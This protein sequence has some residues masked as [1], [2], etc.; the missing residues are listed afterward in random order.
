MTAM[1]EGIRIVEIAGGPAAAFAGMLLAAL[2]ADVVRVEN[3]SGESFQDRE[4]APVDHS[5]AA[6]LARR[7]RR[8]AF[9]IETRAGLRA[10]KV[11][12]AGADGVVED[13]GAAR[14]AELKLSARQ[15]R[16]SHGD[17]IVASVSPFGSTG[18]RASWDAS[19]LV[20]QSMGGIVHS[21]GFEGEPG[22]RVAGLPAHFVAGLHAATAVLTGIFGVRLGMESGAHIEISM[23]E[24]WMHHWVRHI[25]EWGHAGF[26]MQR[27]ERGT[28]R[29]G[30][31]HT[32][33]AS[34]DWLYVLALN[35]AWEPFAMFMGL[36]D[37]AGRNWNAAKTQIEGWDE[38]EPVYRASIASKGRYE[39]F[40]GAAQQGYTFAPI[41]TVDQ[42]AGTPQYLARHAFEPLETPAGT[43]PAPDLPFRLE[44][45]A[46]RPNRAAAAGEHTRD[47]LT[48]LGVDARSIETLLGTP[49]DS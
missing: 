5:M 25:Q 38:I 3:P 1:A 4:T 32:V 23:E 41:H 43:V 28:G 39:W 40:A 34:D 7:K 29:Q 2:G 6:F 21:T 12:V 16:R 8:A 37:Y 13:L 49:Q 33:M 47:V 19:E 48:E 18:P 45:V 14:A 46:R 42:L 10:L 15:L 26:G 36:E 35:A 27:E 20:I 44:G 9:D 30:F 22:L 31:P 17:L 11:L 24:T